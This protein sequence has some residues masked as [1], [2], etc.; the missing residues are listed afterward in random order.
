MIR[1]VI[2][3][4]ISKISAMIITIMILQN[5]QGV[6]CEDHTVKQTCKWQVNFIK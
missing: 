3:H 5:V 4:N 2:I 1:Y 6:V